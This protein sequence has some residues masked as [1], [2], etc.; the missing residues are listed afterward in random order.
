MLKTALKSLLISRWVRFALGYSTRAARW[1][2]SLPARPGVEA[3]HAWGY[4]DE[5]LG[6]RVLSMTTSGRHEFGPGVT[7][8]Y[9]RNQPQQSGAR[10]HLVDVGCA[11]LQRTANC[12]ALP[13]APD[14]LYPAEADPTAPVLGLATRAGTIWR[15]RLGPVVADG[16]DMLYTNGDRVLTEREIEAAAGSAVRV[17]DNKVFDVELV[18][19]PVAAIA[20]SD[21]VLLPGLGELSPV[22]GLYAARTAARPCVYVV[23][24]NEDWV[25][26][27][28]TDTVLRARSRP[29]ESHTAQ[30]GVATLALVPCTGF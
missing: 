19:V 5:C 3:E 11:A 16:A 22:M 7:S 30:S 14:D 21:L 9:G 25:R 13:L 12:V 2:S 8:T 20:I 27:A 18:P 1:T 23:T 17:R 28:R 26:R 6:A 4:C 24:Q 15:R 29:P 10:R